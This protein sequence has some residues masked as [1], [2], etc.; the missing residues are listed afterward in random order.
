MKQILRVWAPGHQGFR[1]CPNSITQGLIKT[2]WT[3]VRRTVASQHR[4]TRNG[5]GQPL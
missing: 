1:P 2:A 5:R 4:N 3:L